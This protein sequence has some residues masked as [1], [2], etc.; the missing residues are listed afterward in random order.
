MSG[1]ENSG[2]NS[3]AFISTQV[4][5][6]SVVGLGNPV[7]AIAQERKGASFPV[8]DL[9]Y[10][11]D[12]G[13]TTTILKER[14]MRE[15]ERDPIFENIDYYDLTKEELRERTMQKISKLVH[16]ITN[17]REVSMIRLSLVG[18]VDMG[19]LT[20]VGQGAAELRNIIGCFCMIELVHGF[21]VAGLETTA[22]FDH[23]TDEFVINT[24]HIGATKWWIDGAAHTAAHT[25]CFARLIVNNK[26]YGVKS[27]VVPLR[28]PK[29]YDLLPGIA[30]GDLGKKMG[31]NGIDNGWVQFTSV[32]IPRQFLLMKHTKVDRQGN[33]T[34]PPLEQFAYGALILGR[35]SM[36]MDSAQVSKRYAS[37]RRQFSSKMEK[38]ETK[39]LD[40]ALHQRR[41]LLFL[42]QTYA[43]QFSADELANSYQL[44]LKKMDKVDSSDSK[45]M[46]VLIEDLK[47]VFSTSAGLKVFTTWQCAETIEHTR[48]SCSGHGYSAYNGFG[49][50]YADW[51]VQC[52]W[53]GDNSILTLSAGHALVQRYIQVQNGKKAPETV[54]YLNKILQLKTAKAGDRNI[55]SEVVLREAWDVVAT[56]T[57]SKAGELFISL[58]K[59]GVATE[60]AFEDTLQIRF[61]AAR[62]HTRAYMRDAGLFLQAGYFVSSQI[63]KVGELC[64]KYCLVICS[65]AVPLTDAFNFTDFFINSAIG[66]YDGNVYENYFGHVKRQNKSSKAQAPYY[67]KI[68]KPMVNREVFEEDDYAELL[69]VDE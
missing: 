12:G 27:F 25:I 8:R 68:I 20:R 45:K 26:D 62:V 53:E 13:E 7:E 60:Q 55:D 17:K 16:Y 51:V 28:D 44:L 43:I 18:V 63:D 1:N 58:K 15:I 31:R 32:R 35:V 49:Q 5:D 10:F 41:L 65:Q 21:N 6:K 14:I 30:I 34:Q 69:D 29:T 46:A 24:P 56:A 37:V 67:D 48:Q 22:T 50:L 40:Y 47:E 33:V 3:V 2:K 4:S 36:A 57:V 11:L 59:S 54:D 64:N 42:E 61:L 38:L 39:L 19:L 23:R 66:R 52:T 9:T